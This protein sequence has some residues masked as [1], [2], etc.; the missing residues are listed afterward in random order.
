MPQGSPDGRSGRGSALSRSQ[1]WRLLAGLD[2]EPA[3]LDRGATGK[4]PGKHLQSD[5]GCRGPVESARSAVLVL[6]PVR[7][8]E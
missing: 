3:D 1:T 4:A 8:T 6:P 5:R 7:F 2:G